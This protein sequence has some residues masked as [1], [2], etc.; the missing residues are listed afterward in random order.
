MVDSTQL[1]KARLID[2]ARE[3]NVLAQALKLTVEQLRH[4]GVDENTI[5][6]LCVSLG[7]VVGVGQW[8]ESNEQVAEKKK[9]EKLR[10]KQE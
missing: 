7:A 5:Q 3:L 6:D 9:L 8:L 2:Q 10:E 4:C 1:L